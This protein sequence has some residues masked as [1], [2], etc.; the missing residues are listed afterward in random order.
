LAINIVNN[1]A[2]MQSMAVEVQSIA[3][4]IVDIHFCGGTFL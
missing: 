2:F 4:R 1:N 3:N